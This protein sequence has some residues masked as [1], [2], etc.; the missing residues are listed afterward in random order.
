MSSLLSVLNEVVQTSPTSTNFHACM[1]RLSI[2][3]SSST[4]SADPFRQLRVDFEH[5]LLGLDK[6]SFL[7]LLDQLEMNKREQVRLHQRQVELEAWT[8]QNRSC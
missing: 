6:S 1:K 2:L 8:Q 5:C 4:Y 7:D 3:M